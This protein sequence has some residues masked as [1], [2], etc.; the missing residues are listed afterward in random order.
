MVS[1]PGSE[2]GGD[3]AADS[4]WVE[5]IYAEPRRQT[6]VRL[7]LPAGSTLQQAVD[8]SGLL[9][10]FPDIDVA[11]RRLGVYGKIS[12]LATVLSAGDRVEIYRPLLTDPKESRKRRAVTATETK[13]RL[14]P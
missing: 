13:K 14:K 8:A 1:L 11:N 12:K 2:M 7:E 6:I 5:V 3:T 9:A 4:I 10:K